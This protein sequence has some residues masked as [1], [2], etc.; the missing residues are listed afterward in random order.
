MK[1][2]SAIIAMVV[3]LTIGGVYA[4]WTYAG[5]D[6]IA[7][8]LAEAK[9]TIADT[10]L[11]GANGTYKI[12]SNLALVVDQANEK[13]EAELLFKSNND[14]PIFLKITFTP[15]VNAPKDIKDNA[16]P[17]ELYFGVTTP[18]Q[19]KIDADGNYSET[20]TPT[21]I[22]TFSNV[23]DGDLDVNITWTNE[24]D[25]FT[26]TLNQSQLEDMISLSQTFV[27]DTKA[28]HDAFRAALAGNIVARV[29]DGTVNA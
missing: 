14:Q 9:V 5:T 22:F 6:D 11:T 7:D 1:K 18:M 4:T 21:D 24:G 17:S 25:K 10:E 3:C 15:S 29:T 20:G 23:S 8:A 28:E 12:E 13:H 26:Y 2:L 27:L 16:V 19:Y